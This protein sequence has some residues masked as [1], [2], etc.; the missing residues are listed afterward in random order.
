MVAGYILL[1]TQPGA[2]KEAARKIADIEGVREVD[3]I[4]GPYD[5]IAY[6]E[7]ATP[8]ELGRLVVS[9][10]QRVPGVEKTL[11]CLVVALEDKAAA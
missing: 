10:I 4:T 3:A 1:N 6:A 7:A 2:L 8:D 9:A 11:T 5:A